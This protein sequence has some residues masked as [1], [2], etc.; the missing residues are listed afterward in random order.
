MNIKLGNLR[1]FT[2]LGDEKEMLELENKLK[3]LGY[4]NEDDCQENTNTER[5]T[6]HI[7]DMPRN[8]NFSVLTSEVISLL[9]QYSNSFNGLVSVSAEKILDDNTK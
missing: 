9:K 3:N 4:L 6:W 1:T 5:K 7:Y 8:I 2:R